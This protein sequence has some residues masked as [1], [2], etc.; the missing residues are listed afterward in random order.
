MM[1]FSTFIEWQFRQMIKGCIGQWVGRWS[2]VGVRSARRVVGF[3]PPIDQLDL[4]CM[5]H[6]HFTKTMLKGG[7]CCF[8]CGLVGYLG[9]IIT[10]WQQLTYLVA[11]FP[12]FPCLVPLVGSQKVRCQ[13]VEGILAGLFFTVFHII[14][15]RRPQIFTLQIGGQRWWQVWWCGETVKNGG[16]ESV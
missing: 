13:V 1:G 11:W 6:D 8:C 9:T 12:W 4:V 2:L 3:Y 5:D 15:S 16:V 14:V 7:F 10:H